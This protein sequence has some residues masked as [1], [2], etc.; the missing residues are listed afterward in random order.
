[1]TQTKTLVAG[2]A[3]VGASSAYAARGARAAGHALSH[4]LT[5]YGVRAASLDVGTAAEPMGLGDEIVLNG[6]RYRRVV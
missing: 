3:S 5:A 1:M 2:G 6:I 4:S